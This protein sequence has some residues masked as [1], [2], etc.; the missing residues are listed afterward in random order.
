MISRQTLRPQNNVPLIV[1]LDKGPEGKQTAKGDYQYTINDDQA[2]MWIPAEAR[3]AILRSHAQAGDEIE[4][5]KSA[6]GWN[7]QVLSDAGEPTGD[8]APPPMPPARQ[9]RVVAGQ[10][11]I[12]G[13]TALAPQQQTQPQHQQSEPIVDLLG[14]LFVTAGRSLQKAHSQLVDEGIIIEA[15]NWEDIRALGISLFIERNRRE[16]RASR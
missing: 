10:R 8:P 13:A 5:L 11:Q 16:E 9:M 4:I 7:V 3:T 1:R 12:N 2:I 15:F 6:R 14:R